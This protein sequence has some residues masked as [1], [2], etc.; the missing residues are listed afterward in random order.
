MLKHFI[1]SVLILSIIGCG[2]NNKTA[3]ATTAILKTDTTKTAT[4]SDTM[5]DMPAWCDTLVLQYIDYLKRTHDPMILDESSDSLLP[6]KWIFEGSN[7]TDTANYLMIHLGYDVTDSAA[8]GTSDDRFSTAGWLYIDSL[9][10]KM[11]A[12]DVARDTA[13]FVDVNKKY[14]PNEFQP[15][16]YTVNGSSA[17]K[18]YFHTTPDSTTRRK[19]F[20]ST[21]EPVFVEKVQN[22]YGYV[23]FYNTNLQVSSGWIEMKNLKP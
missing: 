23:E 12:Y 13:I 3:S 2:N 10:K 15:R 17:N 22:G 5:P 21:N 16:Y 14:G 18:V 7:K 8:D 19:A 4:V 9:T 20:I 1:F 11:Y 6:I